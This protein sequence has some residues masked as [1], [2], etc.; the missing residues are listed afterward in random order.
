MSII[1]LILGLII[2]K[3]IEKLRENRNFKDFG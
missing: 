2:K 1:Y 3:S